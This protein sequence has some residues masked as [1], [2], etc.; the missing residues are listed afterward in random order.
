[1]EMDYTKHDEN[2]FEDAI[3]FIEVVEHWD[4]LVWY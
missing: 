3:I 1:M 4:K 2:S